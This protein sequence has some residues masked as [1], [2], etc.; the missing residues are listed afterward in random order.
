MDVRANP[1]QEEGRVCNVVLL[2]YCMV[3]VVFCGKD[4]RED[5]LCPF[6]AHPGGPSNTYR[7]YACKPV[8]LLIL[9]L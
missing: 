6:H 9:V 1:S 4:G 5:L 2:Y 7:I 3:F 8:Y